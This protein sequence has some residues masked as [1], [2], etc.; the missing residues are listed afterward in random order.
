MQRRIIRYGWMAAAGLA[1]VYL[2][3]GLLFSDHGYL[4][5]RRELQEVERLKQEIDRLTKQREALARQ[6]L[7]LRD[8]PEAIEALIRREL[9][10]VY[11]DEYMLIMPG[12]SAR[13][14]EQSG[15]Q[16]AE[17]SEPSKTP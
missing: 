14:G 7:R 15:A 4:V 2:F 10:Y 13:S 9:G 5:Y 8:D 17:P 11:K 16:A 6:V 1:I 3:Y 12:A